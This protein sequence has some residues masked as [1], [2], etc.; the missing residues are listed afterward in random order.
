MI[1]VLIKSLEQEAANVKDVQA[2]RVGQVPELK[3]LFDA[4]KKAVKERDDATERANAAEVA[5]EK[6]AANDQQFADADFVRN[7]MN[8]LREELEARKQLREKQ[9]E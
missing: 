2:V 9:K 6:A 5:F 3:A 8:E 1:D 7:G 4:Y